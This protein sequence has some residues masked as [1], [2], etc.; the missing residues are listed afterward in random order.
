MDAPSEAGRLAAAFAEGGAEERE[1]AYRAIEDV[2]RAESDSG[3][4][5]GG[6][7]SSQAIAVAAGCA[8]PLIAHVLCAPQSK[9]G[10][11]EYVH[12][13]VL[14]GEMCKVDMAAVCAELWRRDDTGALPW[15]STFTAPDTALAAMLAKDAPWTRDDA[16]VAA[17]NHAAYVSCCAAGVDAG[18]TAASVGAMEWAGAAFGPGG[19][20]YFAAN[21]QPA[22]RYLP[23]ALL[24]LDLIRSEMDTQ[25]EGII[26]GA[27]VCLSHMVQTKP[28][29]AKAVY[30][31]GFLGLFRALMERYNPME[32]IA[33]DNLVA[34]GMFC[35]FKDVV[36]GRQDVGVEVIQP[37]L[38]AGALDIAISALNAY[39]MLGKPEQASV[40]SVN[41]GVLMALEILLSSPQARPIVTSKL[42]GAGADSFRYLMDHPL[43]MAADLGV[44]TGATAVTIAAQVW[45]RDDDGGGLIFKQ[46]DIDKIVQM[47]GHRG[48]LAGLWPMRADHGQTIVNLCTS[49]L[50]KQLL[51]TCEECIPMLVDSLLLDPEHP[52]M[53]NIALQGRT[54]WEAVKAPVQ[55]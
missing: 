43:T 39:Q 45:G 12:A 46:V 6:H 27:G 51:L 26:A 35:A 49:D 30:E 11:D 17:A 25:P 19:I 29:L 40:I 8:R 24:C 3:R 42:R 47:K 2:V 50:N 54:D 37:L 21:L 44:E 55:R 7:P 13:S 23:L 9:V 34:A 41:W 33:R 31:A 14:L 20:P 5:G 52:R 32:R 53:E 22:E 10:R 36:V 48:P 1:A 38:D 4:G 18:L 28:T 16:I 15:V